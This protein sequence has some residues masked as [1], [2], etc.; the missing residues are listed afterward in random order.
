M[1]AIRCSGCPGCVCACVCVRVSQHALSRWCIPA[2]TGRGEGVCPGCVC[3]CVCVSRG[4]CASRYV[5]VCPGGCLPRG[6]ECVHGGVCPR[7]IC[8][9]VCVSREDVSKMVVRGGVSATQPPVNK[10]TDACESI[11]F[12]QILLRTVTTESLPTE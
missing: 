10:M 4:V 2:C 5:C 7:G 1:R 8:P 3:V 6:W 11:R 12:P 9:G